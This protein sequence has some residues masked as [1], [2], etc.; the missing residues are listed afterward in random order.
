MTDATPLSERIRSTLRDHGEMGAGQIRDA[1]GLSG[2]SGS[3]MIASTIRL[4]MPDIETLYEPRP[5]SLRYRLRVAS[6]E[7]E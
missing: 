1:L 2:R 5:P 4:E 6:D 3:Q 7:G